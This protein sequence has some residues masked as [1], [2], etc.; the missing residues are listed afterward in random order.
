MST[1]QMELSVLAV[2]GQFAGYRVEAM[3]GPRGGIGRVYEATR[4]DSGKRVALKVFKGREMGE[5]TPREHFTR[6]LEAHTRLSHPNVVSVHEWGNDPAPYMVM[7]LVR[8]TTLAGLLADGALTGDRALEILAGVAAALD[9]GRDAGLVYRRLQPAGILI[10]D[11]GSSGLGDFGAARGARASELIGRRRLGRFVDYISPEEVEDG[12]PTPASAIYSLGAITFEALT[13]HP[14]FAS[15]HE[16]ATLQAHLRAQPKGPGS[17]R[18]GMPQQLDEA[19][20]R[21]LSKDPDQRQR[22]AGELID[23][24][25][26]AYPGDGRRRERARG[27]PASA[28]RRPRPRVALALGALAG[29]AAAAALGAVAAG[30]GES[31]PAPPKR[32]ET[33]EVRLSHP[34]DWRVARTAPRLA[35]VTLGDPVALSPPNGG[36]ELVAGRVERE[37]LGLPRG[38]LVDLGGVIGRRYPGLREAGTSRRAVA[39]GVPAAEGAVVAAC[40]GPASGAAASAC[41]RVASTVRPRREGAALAAASPSYARALSGVVRRLDRVRVKGRRRLARARTPAGQRRITARL[42]RDY[43]ALATVLARLDAPE[44]A[45]APQRAALRQLRRASRG[46]RNMSRAARARSAK[47]WRAA[48]PSVRSA[49]RRVQRALLSLRRRGYEVR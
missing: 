47:R 28:G 46:L 5:P 32:L 34:A 9:A 30:D 12:E 23:A 37:A 3:L 45:R 2:G 35:G 20:V 29:V 27:A 8:G 22:T 17:E 44:P 39:Y 43:A 41:E 25:K 1:R 7:G 36:I 13:G 21:A 11:D 31:Q 14:P 24:V 6:T 15:E 33:G 10:G 16:R 19:I 42:S 40:F 4:I 48:R 38:Q 18:P 49:D 26:E